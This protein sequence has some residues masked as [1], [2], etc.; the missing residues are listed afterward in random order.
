VPSGRKRG[1][2]AAMAPSRQDVDG[3]RADAYPTKAERKK[4]A[5]C[6]KTHPWSRGSQSK[7]IYVKWL[8][9]ARDHR[10]WPKLTLTWCQA[11]KNECLQQTGCGRSGVAAR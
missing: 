1:P 9:F 6:R 5:P 10:S 2:R 4:G 7:S 11:P 8:T 3:Y